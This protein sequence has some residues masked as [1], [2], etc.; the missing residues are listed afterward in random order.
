M[1]RWWSDRSNDQRPVTAVLPP[2]P[3]APRPITS[4]RLPVPDDGGGAGA[5]AVARAVPLLLLP[6][7]PLLLPVLLPVLLERTAKG[8]VGGVVVV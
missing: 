2:P 1:E 3:L 7:L 5:G 4:D 8:G 6:L